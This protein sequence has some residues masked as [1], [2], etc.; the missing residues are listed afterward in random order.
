MMVETPQ[1][2]LRLKQ[3]L[4]ELDRR[5]VQ[6]STFDDN[7]NVLVLETPIEEEE[8]DASSIFISLSCHPATE[9]SITLAHS[10]EYYHVIRQTSEQTEDELVQR[11]LSDK[12]QDMYYCKDTFLAATL[13]C[14]GL[15]SCVDAVLNMKPIGN[16][17]STRAIAIVRPPGHH[18][19]QQR[20]MGEYSFL[21][22]SPCF[23]SLKMFLT[24]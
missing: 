14:G 8:K 17:S 20:A 19:C 16:T 13:A 4:E 12:N 3:R 15:I 22:F 7:T 21:Q 10:A 6:K 24:S 1:R 5:L 9:K 11:T 2:I 18:A 23:S